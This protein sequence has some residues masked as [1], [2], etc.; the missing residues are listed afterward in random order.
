MSMDEDRIVAEARAR[1]E[2]GAK[3]LVLTGVHLGKYGYD[4]GADESS[5]VRLFGR[6]LAISGVER[7]RLSSILSRHL[8][9][10]VLGYMASQPRICRYLHVP[11]QSGDDRMLEVMHRPYRLSDYLDA[12]D[13]A[14][15]ALPGVALATDIIV[16]HPGEDEEAFENT[17]DVVE[18]VGFS[19][20]HVFRYSERA[21]TKAATM[22]D[23][24]H[25]DVKRARSKRLIALGNDLRTGF[26]RA[27][28]GQRLEV[29]VED[30]REVDGEWVSSGQ[31]EDHVRVWFEGRGL[32]GTTVEV[33]ADRVRSDGL[34]GALVGREDPREGESLKEVAT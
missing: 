2:A 19:K 1:V 20:L 16:G 4:T 28:L 13:R 11:L 25:P 5:L 12:V 26:L 14:K 21:G 7:L 32:L 22:P 9:D 10:E 23:D 31:T 6:L 30:E 17:M 34:R 15:E 29:L 33:V 18:R 8:T 24:V 27:H 3:E